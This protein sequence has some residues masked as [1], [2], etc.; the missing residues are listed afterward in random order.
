[1]FFSIEPSNGLP[2]YDQIIRQVKFAAA[3]ETLGLLRRTL[4][5]LAPPC[6]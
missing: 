5:R 3:S 2:I 6:I 4:S 1:M